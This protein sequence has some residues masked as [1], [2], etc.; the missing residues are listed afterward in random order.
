MTH[1][2]DCI[3]DLMGPSG[4]FAIAS[5][6]RSFDI[7]GELLDSLVDVLR[8][9]FAYARFEE[10]MAGSSNIARLRPSEPAAMQPEDVGEMLDR[11]IEARPLHEPFVVP[12]AAGDG[13]VSIVVLPLGLHEEIGLIVAGSTR[14]DFATPAEML[15][16]RVAAS[17]IALAA[18]EVQRSEKRSS[19]DRPSRQPGRSTES[20]QATARESSARSFDELNDRFEMV[21]DSISDSFWTFDKEWRYTHINKRASTQLERLGKDPQKLIGKSLWEEFPVVPNEAALRRAMSDRV[22]VVDEL[23]YPPLGEWVENHMWPCPD[24][25]LVILQRYI[26][27]RKDTEKKLRRSEAVIAEGQR[28]THTGSWA[29]HVQ[30]GTVFWSEEQFRI[31]GFDS[32]APAPDLAL[33]LQLIH[34]EDRAF[35]QKKLGGLVQ[36]PRDSAWECRIVALD[37]TVKH[38]RSTAHP[39]FESGNLVEYVGTT[40]DITEQVR[41]A[42]ALQKAQAELAHATRAITV[43]QL[44]ASI[45]HELNQPLAALVTNAHASLRWLDKVPADIHEVRAAAERIIRDANRASALIARTRAFAMRGE[46]GRVP[47]DVK[48]LVAESMNLLEVEAQALGVRLRNETSDDL[49]LVVADRAQMQQVIVNL[50]INA[51]DAMRDV[52]NATRVL[53]LRAECE[54]TDTVAVTVRDSGKGI[55]AENRDRIFEPFYTSKEGGMGLGLAISRSIVEAHGGRIW[56]TRNPDRGETFHFTLPTSESASR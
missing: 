17:R 24:G 43:G 3:R 22:P 42:Q 14:P 56:A 18:H 20:R 12:N 39:V 10:T 47:L 52:V 48:N 21:L 9:E 55:D 6:Q 25:G 38:T 40:M 19:P 41:A 13:Q 1:L 7:V 5:G 46:T 30:S 36:D 35:I 26:T 27:E 37:G 44:T 16:L 8:L 45:A 54:G 33:C 50:L 28:L 31:F 32:A 34:P 11:W 53:T 23:Y 29:W 49:P 15:V 2:Q 4:R 51:I